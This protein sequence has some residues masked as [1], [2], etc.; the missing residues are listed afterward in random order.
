MDVERF[1]TNDATMKHFT[2]MKAWLKKLL[3]TVFYIFIVAGLS[4][5]I[6]LVALMTYEDYDEF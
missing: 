4:P 3:R 2:N 6:L 5:L 1:G